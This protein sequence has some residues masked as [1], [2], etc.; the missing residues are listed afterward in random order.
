LDGSPVLCQVASSTHGEPHE[1]HESPAIAALCA[2]KFAAISDVGFVSFMGFSAQHA[3]DL[4]TNLK[5]LTREA[6]TQLE[7]ETHRAGIRSD[8][9]FAFH[10]D[11]ATSIG[12][13]ALAGCIRFLK[14]VG[15]QLALHFD[16]KLVLAPKAQVA[17]FPGGGTHYKAHTDNFVDPTTG[18]TKNWRVLTVIAYANDDWQSEHGGCLRMY[19]GLN[20]TDIEPHAGR[21]VAF[22]SFLKHEVLPSWRPRHAVT[23]WIW[24]EDGDSDKFSRS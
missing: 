22:N 10:E 6:D 7:T 21:I 16:P 14:A 19:D 1:P 4:C 3:T 8:R 9:V 11:E 18:R 5:I 17:C 12:L 2:G 20:H 23:L 13:H 24:R 15:H